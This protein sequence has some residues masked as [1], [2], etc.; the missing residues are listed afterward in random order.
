M[1]VWPV[2]V[3]IVLAFFT[4]KMSMRKLLHIC[5]L[6]LVCS[7][8][9]A[10]SDTAA[11]KMKP[12]KYDYIPVYGFTESIGFGAFEV[13]HWEK[14]FSTL[15]GYNVINIPQM[16]ISQQMM[17]GNT[18]KIARNFYLANGILYGAQLGVEGNN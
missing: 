8:L 2:F 6:M 15:S 7:V 12:M 9:R 1:T 14:F 5:L 18:L 17:I 13:S 10:Q 11:V 4:A 16:F 3:G